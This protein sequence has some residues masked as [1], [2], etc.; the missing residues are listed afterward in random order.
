MPAA[1]HTSDKVLHG[2]MYA[3][4]AAVWIVPLVLHVSGR[5]KTFLY[6]WA[7]TVLFG[8]L[9]EV[10]QRYCTLTRSGEIADVYADA[11]GALL[12]LG[13]VAFALWIRER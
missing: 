3:L 12:G 11:I 8:I 1:M 2:A 7:G 9:M 6:V 5:V 4:L 13:L 10:L